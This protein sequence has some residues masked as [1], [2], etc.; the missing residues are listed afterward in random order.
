MGQWKDRT[1]EEVIALIFTLAGFS[2]DVNI[3]MGRVQTLAMSGLHPGERER[4][5]LVV[6]H[7]YSAP[8]DKNFSSQVEFIGACTST[9]V[10]MQ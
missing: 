1:E 10:Q 3:F 7:K 5:A 4:I 8:D 2:S 9:E 6:E